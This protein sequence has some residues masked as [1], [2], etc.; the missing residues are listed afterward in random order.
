[1]AQDQVIVAA[2]SRPHPAE[3]LNGD[4][5]QVNWSASGDRCRI[6]IVDGLGHGPLAADASASALRVLAAHP[7]L[8]PEDSLRACHRAL[9]A[10]RG[11][12]MSVAVIEPGV[13]RLSYSGVGNTE[14]SIMSS[15]RWERL[16]AYRGI[17]GASLPRLRTFAHELGPDWMLVMFT[18][19]VRSSFQLDE[20]ADADRQ[21]PHALA[22]HILE[23]WSRPTDD[24]TVVVARA[25]GQAT[26]S[27]P[28]STT[29]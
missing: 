29:A 23:N 9:A 27:N 7:E 18:D 28:R 4:A 8:S 6:A 15:G 12:A 25:A 10:T 26:G 14:A 3:S 16:L 24:A 2:A 19:G 21:D 5:W 13:A 22:Q 17:V 11:A 20:I 1:M